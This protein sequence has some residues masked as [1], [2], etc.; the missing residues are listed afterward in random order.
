MKF[1]KLVATIAIIAF[2]VN[3]NAY[4]DGTLR[5][6]SDVKVAQNDTTATSTSTKE[7]N[8]NIN[9]NSAQ[10][11]SAQP[12]TVVEAAPVAESKAEGLRKA[13]QD[14]EVSTEQKIVEK[15]ED[16]RLQEERARADRLFGNKL[17]PQPAV[18]PAPVP[19]PAP[20]VAAPAPAPAPVQEKP[21]QV[22]IEKVEII[23][24]AAIAPV[25]AEPVAESKANIKEE[26]AAEPAKAKYY[27]SG[28]AGNLSYQANNVHSNYGLGVA[29][30]T[31]LD[32]RI[33]LEL[34][35][36]YSNSSIDDI[37]QGGI[38]HKLDQNDLSASGKYYILSGKLKPYLGGSVS[39]INRKYQD[40][41]TNVY[42]N[43]N[44]FGNNGYYS[45]SEST[46]SVDMGVLAGVDFAI[47]E[48]F[49]VGLGVDYNFNVMTMNNM[50]NNQ[51]YVWN[52]QGY[53]SVNVQQLEKINFY[54]IKANAKF[55]F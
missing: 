11:A 21:A 26:A 37:W 47:N 50:P 41:Q 54:A 25:P 7:V 24:P 40:V 14:A 28:L 32:E 45:G 10:Q 39:Y 23:Q 4:S 30:G 15:L 6:G 29:V 3:A 16:S 34:G 48:Q 22:T 44:S 31:I 42:S 19:A 5:R 20:V 27:V 52:G 49:M 46:Q 38:Y 53:Q 36:F 55:T 17:D 9:T 33:A 18:A 51:Y 1:T 2:A 8:I 35:Y 43:Q 12:T 13:R